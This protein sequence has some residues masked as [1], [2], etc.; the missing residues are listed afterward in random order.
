[1][2]VKPIKASTPDEAR[3][4][5]RAIDALLPRVRITDLLA[6][7]DALTGFSSAFRELRSGKAHDNTSC[8]LAAVLADATNL[9]LERMANASQGVTYAQLA[10]TQS[11]YLSEE[12]YRAALAKIMDVHHAQPFARHWGDGL[13]SSSDGQFFRSGRRRSGAGDINAKYGPEPGL[14]IYTH[15]SDMHGSF[16]TKVLSATASEAP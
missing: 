16:H 7:I 5:D 6:E 15:L 1:M 4:L 11:W 13:S 14:R 8:V 12:N 2:S 3:V 10:W 9:G